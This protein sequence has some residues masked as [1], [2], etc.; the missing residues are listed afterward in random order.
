MQF[1]NATDNCPDC[2]Q[3]GVKLVHDSKHLMNVAKTRPDQIDQLC[4]FIE[5]NPFST[6]SGYYP[7]SG[8]TRESIHIGCRTFLSAVAGTEP[9]GQGWVNGCE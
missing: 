4:Y 2:C 7:E 8:C 1:C 3:L 6:A 5:K 9:V